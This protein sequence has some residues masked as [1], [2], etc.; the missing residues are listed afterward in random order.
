MGNNG[1]KIVSILIRFSENVT[2]WEILER[3][4]HEKNMKNSTRR[5]K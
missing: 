5:D 4:K 2:L 3:K 1:E